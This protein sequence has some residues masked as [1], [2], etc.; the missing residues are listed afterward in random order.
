M[1]EAPFLYFSYGSNMLGAH[2]RGACPSARFVAA[3]RLPDHRLAFTLLSAN[4]WHGG[5]ADVLPDA[6]SEVWGALWLLD[7]A[8]SG[9]LDTAEGLTRTP[10]AYERYRVT[11]TTPAG[12]EV[13]CRSYRV[14]H[15]S[16]EVIS[17]SPPF[18][19]T[20]IEGAHECGLPASY[21]AGL[22]AIRDNGY[23]G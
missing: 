20:L 3:A 23:G 14:A 1:P 7:E 18:K 21:I 16:A 9:A 2:L 15:P 4:T 5:V 13:T 22:D 17:P 6:T 11:V 12:D 19:A 8:D 10:P